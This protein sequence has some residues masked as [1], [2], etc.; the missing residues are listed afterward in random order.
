MANAAIVAIGVAAWGLAVWLIV[1][2]RSTRRVALDLTEDMPARERLARA[3]ARVMGSTAGAVV[4]GV[5]VLGLGSR[6]MMRVLAATSPASA[7]GRSTDADEVVGVISLDGTIGLLVFVG[8]FGGLLGLGLFVVLRRWLPDRSIRAGLVTG[9]IGAGLLARPSGLLE[10]SN[11]DFAILSPTWL[12]VLLALAL[13]ITFALLAAVLID[14]W[15]A[16][17]PVPDRT[18]KG[19]AGLVPLVPLSLGVFPALAAAAA[20]GYKAF[21]APGGRGTERFAFVDRP[22]RA[23]TVAAA[24]LGGAWTLAAAAQILTA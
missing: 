17:W 11:R 9:G 21:V 6:L 23:V 8:L 20:I 10:P 16:S 7:Q 5:L 15:A 2:L 1:R 14:R 12:A 24:V 4:A 18:L 19:A 13:V 3:T 22:L